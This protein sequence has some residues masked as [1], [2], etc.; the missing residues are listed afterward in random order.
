MLK[1]NVLHYFWLGIYYRSTIG[2]LKIPITIVI[3]VLEIPIV[4]DSDSIGHP[5]AAAI[6]HISVY[7]MHWTSCLNY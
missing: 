3:V 1:I 2:V 5:Y 6:T 7:Y 4:T